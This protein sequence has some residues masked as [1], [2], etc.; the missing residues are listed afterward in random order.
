[1]KTRNVFISSIPV[2]RSKKYK[3]RVTEIYRLLLLLTII[4]IIIIIINLSNISGQHEIKELHKASTLGIQNGNLT[5]RGLC[6]VIHSY[7]KSQRDALFLK[8]I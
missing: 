2:H 5:F 6:I 4:I 1:M 8:F 7:N 3:L